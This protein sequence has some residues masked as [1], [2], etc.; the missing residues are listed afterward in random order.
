M[1]QQAEQ[2]KSLERKEG[3]GIFFFFFQSYFPNPF[4]KDFEFLFSF[5]QNQSSQ[6]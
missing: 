5:S 2:A 4:S 1:G 6:K 3:K